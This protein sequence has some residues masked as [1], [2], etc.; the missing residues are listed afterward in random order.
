M[1]RLLRSTYTSQNLGGSA[2][3]QQRPEPPPSSVARK[4][5]LTSHQTAKVL[6]GAEGE[7]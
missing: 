6:G 4:R 1:N 3:Q 5:Q 2:D 7:R